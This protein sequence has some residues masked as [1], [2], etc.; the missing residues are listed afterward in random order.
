MD[1]IHTDLGAVHDL[2]AEVLERANDGGDDFGYGV[3]L[4]PRTGRY[5]ALVFGVVTRGGESTTLTHRLFQS[6]AAHPV[7][8]AGRVQASLR[9]GKSYLPPRALPAG[10]LD[11][12]VLHL[13]FVCQMGAT[14]ETVD[15]TMPF[16]CTVFAGEL[17]AP[18]VLLLRRRPA[19]WPP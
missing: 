3:A 6:L 12:P 14:A 4:F 9:D 1:P 15:R 19:G 8:V 17:R 16:E 10:L 11:Q 18:V 2:L 5:E 7:W 13:A